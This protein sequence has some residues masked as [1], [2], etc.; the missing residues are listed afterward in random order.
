VA[1]GA[2]L[3]DA[4]RSAGVGVDTLNRWLA[5]GRREDLGPFAALAADVADARKRA[6][7]SPGQMS[8]AE[9]REHLERSVRARSVAA[10]KL[11]ADRFLIPPEELPVVATSAPITRLAQH[12]NPGDAA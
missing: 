3:A 11:W 8:A 10:M 4:A 7:Q 9:S 1:A 12:R 5:R 6:Q 2:S